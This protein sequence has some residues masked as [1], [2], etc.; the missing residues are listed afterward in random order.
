M[1]D[2]GKP[3]VNKEKLRKKSRK[4]SF[5]VHI[6][7]L[8]NVKSQFYLFSVEATSIQVQVLLKLKYQ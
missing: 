3:A 5:E 7:Q 2:H 4:L 1:K 8:R 6:I